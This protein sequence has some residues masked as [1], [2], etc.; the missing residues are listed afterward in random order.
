M[1]TS[2]W[3]PEGPP[4]H[5]AV[6]DSDDGAGD[7]LYPLPEPLHAESVTLETVLDSA[8]S[9]GNGLSS[10]REVSPADSDDGAEDELYPLPEPLHAE[11]VTLETVFDSAQSNG[12]GQSSA[13]EVSPAD[14]DD[15][16][17]DELYPLPE[18]LHAE[19][20]T[21]ET[22]LDSAQSNGNGLSSAREVSPADSD[23][24]AEDELHPLPEPLHAESG[25]L[26]TVFDSAQSNGNGLSSTRGVSPADSDDGAE[27]ELYP[28]PEPLHAESGTLETVLDSAQSNG[29]GVPS[30]REVSPALV[31]WGDRRIT[32]QHLAVVGVVPAIFA[33]AVVLLLCQ[34]RSWPTRLRQ[35]A[36]E[37]LRRVIIRDADR[38]R[39]REVSAFWRWRLATATGVVTGLRAQYERAAPE[40]ETDRAADRE[41]A[42]E[43]REAAVGVEA[44]RR[45]IIRDADRSRQREVS[46]FWRWRLATA[47]G[48]VTGLRAQYERAAPEHETDRAAD[49]EA[50]QERRE[51]AVGVVT[52][53]ETARREMGETTLDETREAAAADR[54]EQQARMEELEAQIHSTE[55]S[56]G[57]LEELQQQLKKIEEKLADKAR[58]DTQRHLRQRQQVRHLV[59]E[60]E[61]KHKE[62]AATTRAL[63]EARRDRGSLQVE[64][65]GLS[66]ALAAKEGALSAIQDRARVEREDAMANA[67]QL[68]GQVKKLEMA[69]EASYLDVTAGEAA[70]AGAR[71]E[72]EEHLARQVAL[73]RGTRRGAQRLCQLQVSAFRLWRLAAVT[74]TADNQRLSLALMLQHA[75][76][77][78][79][80]RAARSHQP[81]I[82][83]FWRWRLA[84]AT[85]T[86]A[87]LRQREREESIGRGAAVA[88][89][90]LRR[91][92]ASAEP[93]TAR[94]EEERQELPNTAADSVEHTRA[95]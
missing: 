4:S 54:A 57:V 53:V 28:L 10:A 62:V 6:G 60:V 67:R 68:E 88:E 89:T 92:D 21:L 71:A 75:L 56:R 85:V 73:R 81:Q 77:R 2:A 16:A 47:T 27:D 40:H 82:S 66:V 9:N 3:V 12:N 29:T 64:R 83:A 22:V 36:P 78:V 61:G 20:G 43:R 11:S 63:T 93:A 70:T 84:T 25:T 14:S 49:R 15:G 5:I 8:Q 18:P 87:I 65:D 13:R 91:R 55:E 51:A 34:W 1:G 31:C 90:P 23:D 48:V 42:Q 46:A 44:L 69:L 80:Q 59:K 33:G 79:I 39:Q 74:T 86:A 35:Q 50:A 95:T 76:G 30:A 37:A 45:V 38:S 41:A 58:E 17:E 19:S 52:A 26:E 32:Q 72:A 24:G 7:E 94:V